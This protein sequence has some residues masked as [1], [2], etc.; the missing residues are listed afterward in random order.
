MHVRLNERE[1]NPNPHV[2]FI[3]ALPGEDDAEDAK[4]FLRALA[5]QVR[6]LMQRHGFGVNSLEEYEWNTVFAGRNW[7]NGETIE[8]VLRGRSGRF[9]PT[10]WLLGTFCHELA[11]IKHMNH[12]P[13]FQALWRK[14]RQEVRELQDKGYYGDGFW[15]SGTRLIDSSNIPGEGSAAQDMPEYICGGA[16]SKSRPSRRRR[17]ERKKRPGE[18][19]ASTKTG[20]QTERKRKAGRR[21]TSKTAFSG[22]GN[23]L[24]A[25]KED[26]SFGKQA[27]SKR[28]REERAQAA[29]KR[30]RTL[31]GAST[32]R[33]DP[34]SSSD[35]ETDD[36]HALETDAE[37]RHL[38]PSDEDLLATN[39]NDF[40][41][42]FLFNSP[43]PAAS[44][45]TLC[46]NIV[47][48]E[49]SLRKKEAVGL[50]PVNDASRVLGR[51][52]TAFTEPEWTCGV[53]TLINK[54]TFLACDACGMERPSSST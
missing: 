35:D 15:S 41:S 13:A 33:W 31:N 36:D 27:G 11:H 32:S 42:D 37:R 5:A 53:C 29:E 46:K 10:S 23:T 47:E 4:Q 52:S 48:A 6:P 17:G 8:L 22:T 34:D 1:Q 49:I 16:Q 19:L 25:S 20:R 24:S 26:G 28:A 40:N 50:A 54:G 51:R 43:S 2:N 3:T 38:L 30:L 14:L 21:V 9:L 45:S 44:G 39:W 7:N 18:P 12:G